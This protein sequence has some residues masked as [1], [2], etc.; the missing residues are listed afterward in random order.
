MSPNDLQQGAHFRFQGPALGQLSMRHGYVAAD[1]GPLSREVKSL[2]L[3][4]IFVEGVYHFEF[5]G[6][7][8]SILPETSYCSSDDKGPISFS[9]WFR[10]PHEA[11]V[12]VVQNQQY[13]S[14]L[15]AK[16]GH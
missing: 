9:A 13:A 2:E 4:I 7:T 12:T 6:E 5:K 14:A 15:A 16:Y 11:L 8:G 3:S 1:M 10:F